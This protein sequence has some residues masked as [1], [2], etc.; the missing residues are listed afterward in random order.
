M[1][2]SQGVN[3]LL[4]CGT[5]M[6]HLTSKALNLLTL[7]NV[8]MSPKCDRS[9]MGCSHKR[10]SVTKDTLATHGHPSHQ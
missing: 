3:K 7:N 5:Q 4:Q 6:A 1:F 10:H 9:R 2:S 8:L